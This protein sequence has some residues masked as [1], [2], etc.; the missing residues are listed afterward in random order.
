MATKEANWATPLDTGGEAFELLGNA[1]KAWIYTYLRHHPG[2]TIQEIVETLDQPERTVYDY[3]EDLEDA[4]FVE[5]SN[6][7]RPAEYVAHEIELQLVE[8]DAERRITPELIEAIARR[9]RDDDV[10]AYIDRHG[11]DG[12]AVALDYAREYV[13]GSVTHQIMAR[14][15]DISSVEAGVILDALRP[16]VEG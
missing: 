3:V 14:E 6:D 7:G 2:A 1:R 5:Q 4:R 10:D 15:R 11:L 13:D 9:I 12:L 16:V 8:G